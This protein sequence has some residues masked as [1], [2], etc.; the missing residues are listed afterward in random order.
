LAVPEA[1]EPRSPASASEEPTAA[2]A[3]AA[4]AI[5]KPNVAEP[6]QPQVAEK[7]EPA[8]EPMV[9]EATTSQAENDPNRP[10]RSGWWQRARA[11]L[12]GE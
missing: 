3:S 6:V 4:A 5:A 9:D 8:A 1:V 11:T 7:E 2:E 12:V 10:R